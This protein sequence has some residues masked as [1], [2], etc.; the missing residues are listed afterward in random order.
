MRYF[1]LKEGK[2][3]FYNNLCKNIDAGRK[4]IKVK[5]GFK[6]SLDTADNNQKRIY[7]Y[8]RYNEPDEVN[9]VKLLLCEGDCFI[10]IGANIGYFTFAAVLSTGKSGKVISFEPNPY[11]FEILSQNLSLNNFNCIDLHQVALGEASGTAILHFQRDCSDGKASIFKGNTHNASIKVNQITLDS[12]I[13]EYNISPTVIKIDAEGSE[14][15]IL[16][17]SHKTL[18]SSS[19]PVLLIESFSNTS[20]MF[21]YLS[22]LDYQPYILSK[23]VW[24]KY[25]NNVTSISNNTMWVRKDV[26]TLYE[27]RIKSIL[28][29]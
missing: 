5:D 25:K 4:I 23:H 19:S 13:H 22:S 9:L 28:A 17:G 16:K 2:R 1:P 12:F 6:M 15:A 7:W 8:G 10:D 27:N 24:E 3:V 29:D 14:E 11:T 18:S 21:A 20:D 26:I